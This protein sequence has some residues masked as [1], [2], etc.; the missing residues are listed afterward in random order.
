[1]FQII[2]SLIDI[3][4]SRYHFG[5]FVLHVLSCLIFKI[6]SQEGIDFTIIQMKRLRLLKQQNQDLIQQ[7]FE[8]RTY[9]CDSRPK[10]FPFSVW[11][12]CRAWMVNSWHLYQNESCYY[13]LHCINSKIHFLKFIFKLKNNCFTEFCWFLPYINMN[14]PQAYTCPL[15]PEPP[16]HLPRHPTLLGS[17]RAPIQLTNLNGLTQQTLISHHAKPKGGGAL[18]FSHQTPVD[19]GSAR[20][21][22]LLLLR[23]L[24]VLTFGCQIQQIQVLAAVG[25]DH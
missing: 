4:C 25:G 24:E 14:Q 5:V 3:F 10:Q 20:C 22:M 7:K 17:H 1:M 8:P 23:L 6:F 19:S 12:S 15:P 18:G 11:P 13:C 9:W 16:S 2:N 21:S